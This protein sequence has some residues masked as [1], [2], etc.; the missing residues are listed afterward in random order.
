M[1]GNPPP[2]PARKT[3]CSGATFRRA[4]FSA[5]EVPGAQDLSPRAQTHLP[6]GCSVVGVMWKPKAS[7]KLSKKIFISWSLHGSW[8]VVCPDLPLVQWYMH[9][10][11]ICERGFKPLQRPTEDF[12]TFCHLALPPTEVFLHFL[13]LCSDLHPKL[14]FFFSC[15]NKSESK[16]ATGRQMHTSVELHQTALHISDKCLTERTQ[17]SQTFPSSTSTSSSHFCCNNSCSFSCRSWKSVTKTKFQHL[18]Q[19]MDEQKCYWQSGRQRLTVAAS[20]FTEKH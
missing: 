15:R 12:S 10:L 3:Q 18:C 20:V 8:S 1:C 5:K 13:S 16:V 2:V 14:S 17:K 11:Q 7:L 4:V 6:F 19:W 9:Q